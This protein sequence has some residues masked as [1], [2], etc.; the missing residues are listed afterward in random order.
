[1]LRNTAFLRL[2]SLPRLWEIFPGAFGGIWYGGYRFFE[3]ALQCAKCVFWSFSYACHQNVPH[4]AYVTIYLAELAGKY[5]HSAPERAGR[6]LHFAILY[7]GFA[8]HYLQDSFSA[9]HPGVNRSVFQ[10]IINDK[11][12]HDFYSENGLMVIIWDLAVFW[13]SKTGGTYLFSGKNS[14]RSEGASGF[15]YKWR[16]SFYVRAIRRDSAGTADRIG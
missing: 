8:D 15:L 12:M 5:Y 2:M 3:S 10:S 6:Y 4:G 16:D 14:R 9:G 7:N 13:R 11:A 1:M